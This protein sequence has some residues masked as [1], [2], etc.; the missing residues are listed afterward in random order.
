[1]TATFIT[2]RRELAHR[3][4]DEIEVTLFWT[5]PTNRVEIAI[6]DTRSDS[7]LEFEVDGSVALDAFNHPFAY[8][9]TQR[10]RSVAP[11]SAAVA[12]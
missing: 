2:D 7:A 9:A 5:K 3:T 11:L 4:S 10:V 6:L 1:M 8:A 12:H